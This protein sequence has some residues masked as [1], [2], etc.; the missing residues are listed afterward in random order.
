MAEVEDVISDKIGGFIKAI[1]PGLDIIY[2]LAYV[3]VG[4]AIIWALLKWI[5]FEKS[6]KHFIVIRV[7]TDNRKRIM[8]DKFREVKDKEGVLW[9]QLRKRKDRIPVAPPD[10]IELT[11][12][13]SIYVEAYYTP[14]GEYVFFS[15]DMNKEHLKE[16][17]GISWT[18]ESKDQGK[19]QY[20]DLYKEYM[21]ILQEWQALPFYKK[22]NLP[23]IRAWYIKKPEAPQ[24]NG[25]FVYIKDNSNA[26]EA[27]QPLTT[28]QRLILVSQYKKAHDRKKFSFWQNLPQ[29][30]A[31]GGVV[32]ILVIMLV[33]WEDIA[34]PIQD[35]QQKGLERDQLQLEATKMLHDIILEKQ[36]IGQDEGTRAIIGDTPPP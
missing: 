6:Y 7:V 2:L 13:G 22:L 4:V 26:I 5:Q 29:I 15:D 36:R 17:N 3:I 32:M 16:I 19:I 21:Q 10:A 34:K 25:R 18:V 27:F 14:E 24:L 23:F 35:M 12:K 1:S 9:W 28:K 20:N 8:T 30:A 31:I 11:A 33:F